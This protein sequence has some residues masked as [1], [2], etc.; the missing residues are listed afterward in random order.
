VLEI[1]QRHAPSSAAMVDRLFAAGDIHE[2]P[3]QGFGSRGEK[4]AAMVPLLSW[5][6]SD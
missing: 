1:L 3:S 6:I 5:S 4:V 2:N